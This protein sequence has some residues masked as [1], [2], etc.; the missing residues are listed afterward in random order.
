MT[1]LLSRDRKKYISQQY[2]KRSEGL[3]GEYYDYVLFFRADLYP[4][5][6]IR[7]IRK[8][9]KQMI[10]YQYDGMEVSRRI[11]DY[12]KYFNKIFVFDPKDYHQYRDLRFLPLTNC[13]FP[14]ESGKAEIEGDFFYIGVGV[15]DRIGKIRRFSQ[16]SEDENLKIK[17]LLTVP[18]HVR[19]QKIGGGRTVS[20]GN[21]LPRKYCKCEEVQS[22]IRYE[23]ILSQWIEFQIF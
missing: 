20:Y 23:I 1:F 10:T 8:I 17:A 22:N 19:S 3:L 16:Y 21:V 6:V 14:D 12:L 15:P 13:W 11:L 5:E 9:S 7:N 4:E 18:N 2:I